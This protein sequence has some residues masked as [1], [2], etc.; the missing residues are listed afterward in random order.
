MIV[1]FINLITKGLQEECYIP[2]NAFDKG[3]DLCDLKV[4]ALSLGNYF[5]KCFGLMIVYKGK[6]G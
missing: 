2:G 4:L 5:D 6:M 1:Y 3:Y